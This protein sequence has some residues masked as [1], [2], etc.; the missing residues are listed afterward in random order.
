V[1]VKWNFAE[2]STVVAAPMA[3]T[4]SRG[5]LDGGAHCPGDNGLSVPSMTIS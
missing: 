2:L 4:P 3:S 5:R 1:Q